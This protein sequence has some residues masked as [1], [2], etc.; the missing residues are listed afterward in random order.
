MRAEPRTKAAFA[1]TRGP[2]SAA[3]HAAHA[4]LACGARAPAPIYGSAGK[5]VR[6]AT[7]HACLPVKIVQYNFIAGGFFKLRCHLSGV[8]KNKREEE[9]LL[10]RKGWIFGR[11]RRG[12]MSEG[13]GASLR[14]DRRGGCLFLICAV[15]ISARRRKHLPRPQSN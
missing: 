10:P 11:A 9:R 12:W 7:M 15:C 2:R 8:M 4:I 1:E 6:A 3:S 5:L 14:R 13:R